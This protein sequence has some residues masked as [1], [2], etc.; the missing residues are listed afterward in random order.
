MS[1]DYAK[2]ASV[3]VKDAL[4]TGNMQYNEIID[5]GKPLSYFPLL[6]QYVGNER[7]IVKS[8]SEIRSGAPFTVIETNYHRTD[9]AS[10]AEVAWMEDKAD[11]FLDND[12]DPHP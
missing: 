7:R 8:P 3:T 10:F 4:G 12:T 9:M 1:L 5:S 11:G 6:I 2:R